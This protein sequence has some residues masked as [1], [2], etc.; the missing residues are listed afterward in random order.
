MS[1]PLTTHVLDTATGMPAAGLSISLEQMTGG[2]VRACEPRRHELGWPT[3]R[4]A[5]CGG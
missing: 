5:H 3:V 1:N 4:T 2:A